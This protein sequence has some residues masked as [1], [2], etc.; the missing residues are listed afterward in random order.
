[1]NL[2]QI[3]A[4]RVRKKKLIIAVEV[5]KKRD[6]FNCD[7]CTWGRHCDETN[8]APYDK[9]DLKID[10]KIE[11]TRICPLGQVTPQSNNLLNLYGFYKQGQLCLSGGVLE[12]PHKYLE[13]MRIIDNQVNSE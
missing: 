6:A 4:G 2:Q 13:A 7:N 5:A 3:S 12:Q 10:G 8:P 1:S 9:W 11:S